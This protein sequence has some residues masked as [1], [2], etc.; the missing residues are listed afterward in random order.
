MK[1]EEYEKYKK[2]V[3]AK[4]MSRVRGAVIPDHIKMTIEKDLRKLRWCRDAGEAEELLRRI[5][6]GY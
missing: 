5:E 4:H 2:L 6:R 1:H 3:I